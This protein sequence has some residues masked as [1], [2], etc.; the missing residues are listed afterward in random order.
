MTYPLNTLTTRSQVEKGTGK[1]NPIAVIKSILAKEGIA[2]LYSGI[3]SA[4]FGI[5]VTQYIYY[6]WYETVKAVF[7]KS[8]GS[9]QLSI[10][11][12]MLVKRLMRFR[13]VLLQVQQQLR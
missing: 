12:N 11:E 7:E 6:Y 1:T 2:G 3:S 4:M 10:G 8:A 9:R 13:L 5:A